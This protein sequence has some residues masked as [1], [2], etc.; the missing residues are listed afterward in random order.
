MIR[1]GKNIFR[2]W[3][4]L[5]TLPWMIAALDVRMEVSHQTWEA[6]LRPR[7][8]VRSYSIENRSMASGGSW[9]LRYHRIQKNSRSFQIGRNLTRSGLPT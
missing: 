7:Q 4:P 2:M 5:P 3:L 8:A 9:E 6:R 1:G